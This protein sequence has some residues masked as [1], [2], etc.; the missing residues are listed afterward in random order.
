MYRSCIVDIYIYRSYS[1]GKKDGHLLP[2][3]AQQNVP[4]LLFCSCLPHI[5]HNWNQHGKT[6]MVFTDKTLAPDWGRGYRLEQPKSGK[7][8]NLI[9]KKKKKHNKK[10]MDWT[11]MQKSIDCPGKWLAQG[12][13]SIFLSWFQEGMTCFTIAKL[14][15]AMTLQQQNGFIF[16]QPQKSV[17]PLLGFS[18]FLER[19]SWEICCSS[20][21]TYG[22]QIGIGYPPGW[23]FAQLC[24]W[25]ELELGALVVPIAGQ[26]PNPNIS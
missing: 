15:L 17:K 10:H 24:H 16:Y 20:N 26:P 18:D 4:L 5:I 9:Q 13:F 6:N 19:Q 11:C 8:G 2:H 21:L 25:D 3:G 14:G 23:N 7:D 1:W 22:G 12:G